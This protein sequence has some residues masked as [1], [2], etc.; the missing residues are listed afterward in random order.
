MWDPEKYLEFAAY[1]Q[2]P[3]VDLLSRMGWNPARRVVDLGCGAGD[4]TPLLTRRW[5]GARLEAL[6]SSPEMVRAAVA[7]GI[8]ARVGDV[9]EWKPPSET[10]VVFCNAVLHW[11]PGH[12]E[13]VR[14]WLRAL[15]SGAVLGMQVPGNFDAPAHRT[16]YQLA[17]EPEWVEVLGGVPRGLECVAEPVE[18]ARGL[19]EPGVRVDAWESTYA[20]QLY[21]ADP[22]LDWLCGTAL[23]PVRALLDERR[24]R[25]FLDE[26]AP[27]LREVYPREADG[28]TWFPFRR[29][30]VV[31]WRE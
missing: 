5:P 19:T 15:G 13:L 30:F 12:L 16:L 31:A 26:L 8:P 18:Y 14:D 1:R 11:V 9:R 2:R 23:R 22:V 7:A 25:C 3:A 29:I 17:T 27:R 6:D 20:H 10:D 4:V 24:W 21:G 28:S